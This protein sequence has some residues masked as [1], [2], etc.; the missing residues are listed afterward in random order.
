MADH[1]WH[2]LIEKI[3]MQQKN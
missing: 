1:K 2:L 3:P